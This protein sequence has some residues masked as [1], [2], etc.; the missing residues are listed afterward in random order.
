MK[1]S[2]QLVMVGMV[3]VFHQG[4][5]ALEE[6]ALV[7][8]QF[9]TDYFR[10]PHYLEIPSSLHGGDLYA[11]PIDAI[12]ILGVWSDGE[13]VVPQKRDFREDASIKTWNIGDVSVGFVLPGKMCFSTCR[14]VDA[15]GEQRTRVIEYRIDLSSKVVLLK[16]RF[17]FPGGDDP[18]IRYL[19]LLY[20]YGPDK[21][22][23]VFEVD[24][25]EM[26][27]AIVEGHAVREA[28]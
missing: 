24:Y 15:N 14:E 6:N 4:L 20:S 1:R 7:S 26:V 13:A 23:D 11:N 2:L 28:M 12:E 21:R 25:R 22:E 8:V 3:S 18:N 9:P 17:R 16:Y 10:S 5:H 27:E 19:L